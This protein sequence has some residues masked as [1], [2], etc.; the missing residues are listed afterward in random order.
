[1]L[2][3]V[4]YCVQ[5]VQVCNILCSL[6]YGWV[7]DIAPDNNSASPQSV[8][9]AEEG[10]NITLHIF[11]TKNGQNPPGGFQFTI[12]A[13]G[14][15]KCNSSLLPNFVSLFYIYTLNL[16]GLSAPNATVLPIYYNLM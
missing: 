11:H 5:N 2:W 1:M 9:T 10:E 15:S 12:E 4:E 7:E 6:V 14:N 8:I 3:Y 16:I 13:G